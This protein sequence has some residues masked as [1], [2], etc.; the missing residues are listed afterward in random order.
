MNRTAINRLFGAA[1]RDGRTFLL[2]DE[3]Y[4]LLKYAGLPAPGHFFLGR[5]ESVPKG[6]LDR[7]GSDEVVL[8]IVSPLILHKSDVGG[9]RFVRSAIKDVAVARDAMIGEV[10]CRFMSWSRKQGTGGRT[11]SRREVDES[12]RGVL[13]CEKV[14]FENAGYG[15]EILIGVRNSREF[16]PV[17]TI[18]AGGLDVEYMNERIRDGQAAAV[19]S[20]I[21]AVNRD[22][23]PLLEP[24]AF[25]GK[26]ARP[27]RGRKPIVSPGS[28]AGAAGRFAGLAAAFSAQEITTPFV[29]EELEANPFVISGGRMVP[30][31]GLCRFS[32][33][34]TPLE[35]RPAGGVGSLLQPASIG[36][37]GVSERLNIGHMILNNILANGFPRDRVF[38]VK[39]GLQE[40]EGC[41]CV[42]SVGE[43]P[44]PV[45]MFV[46]T[47]AA[48]QSYGIM[49]EI[50]DGQKARSVI[51]IAGGLGE[52]EGTQNLEGMIR[53]LITGARK[54]GRIAPVVNG[55]NCLGIVSKPGRYDTTFIPEYK[56]P[57]PK[58]PK[59]DMAFI[60]QSGAF[61]ISRMS[62][63]PSVEPLY[64]VSLGNQIDLTASDY[65][66]RLKD[67]PAVRTYAVY[68]E[69][70]KPGDGLTFARAVEE[71]TAGGRSVVV[72]KAGR[73]PEGRGAASSHTASVAGDYG[74]CKAVL[75]QAGAVVAGDIF[76]FENFMKGMAS[77]GDRVVRGNRVG[78]VSNAGFECVIMADS[79][80]GAG[81]G[82]VLAEFT[83]A[84]KARISAALSPLG[85][86]K[87]QDVHN[88]LDVTPVGDDAAFSACAEAVLEDPNVDCAVIS[89]VPMTAAMQTLAPSA[90]YRESILD[91]ASFAQRTIVLF[92]KTDK[93]FVVNIDAGKLYDPL[94]DL[95]EKEGIPVFRRSDEALRFLRTFVRHRAE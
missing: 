7:L 33:A 4:R 50:V 22:L 43:L 39:P 19:A 69:G 73:S 64:A 71:I 83:A 94:C 30:L 35:S 2:E 90:D 47:L 26:I 66:M 38:V 67:D 29:I 34:K 53:D 56:L 59:S 72:Y 63:M 41:R 62:K 17:L 84:T 92:R 14:R 16:G 95:L 11:I 57:R 91:P 31:D 93:P 68:M 12:I 48:E 6:A 65:L 25:F 88:P 78:L 10:P 51:L 85:I 76:E 60:S 61:M 9:V 8:K 45:D 3:V 15:S 18:G 36:I 40:I 89:P 70:F 87:L 5:N 58:S 74:I 20:A 75:E 81:G 49:K 79:L 24:L 32:R 1:E 82:L 23:A 52:K 44:G 54:A 80:K 21:L 46:L 86:D 27:F 77:L 55:G 28:L 37:I 42:P 13:V